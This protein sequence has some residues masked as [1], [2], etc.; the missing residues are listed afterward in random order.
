MS[1]VAYIVGDVFD[2]TAVESDVNPSSLSSSQAPIKT[3]TFH[4][5]VYPHDR[6]Y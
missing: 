5:T 4:S 6:V 2:L 3:A 1:H